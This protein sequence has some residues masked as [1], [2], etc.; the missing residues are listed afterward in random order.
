MVQLGD[1]PIPQEPSGEASLQLKS[2][3]DV[4]DDE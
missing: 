1:T 3:M 2:P 4:S